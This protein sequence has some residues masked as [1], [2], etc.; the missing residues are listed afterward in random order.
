MADRIQESQFLFFILGS[1][2]V[3]QRKHEGALSMDQESMQK[4][5]AIYGHDK[6]HSET[7]A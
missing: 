3:N 6:G 7:A 1:A 4:K 5:R 2:Y